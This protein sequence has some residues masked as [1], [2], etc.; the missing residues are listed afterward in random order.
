MTKIERLW[1]LLFLLP[2]LS[3]CSSIHYQQQLAQPP[4][5][6]ARQATPPD[7]RCLA[8]PRRKIAIFFD[9]TANNVESDT[10][11][12][13]L[14]SLVSLQD[15][16]DIATLYIEGV[17]VDSDL[18]GA[19]TG[20]GFRNRVALAYSFLLAHYRA[21]DQIYVFGFSRGAYQAR[22]LAS[23]LYYIGLPD[24]PG[25]ASK[26]PFEDRLQHATTLFDEMKAGFHE[27]RYPCSIAAARAP[28]AGPERYKSRRVEVLGLWD[29]VEALGGGVM[30]WSERLLHKAGIAPFHVD[31]DEPN[32]R[33]GDQL[34]NVNHVFHAV[35]LDDDREWIFTPLLVSRQ[36]LLSNKH[37][38]NRDE[39]STRF[40][41]ACP[42]GSATDSS[43]TEIE[44]PAKP[45]APNIA[46]VW[47]A[48]AH[49]DV[50]GGYVGSDLPGVSLNWMIG[51]L[52]N[53][54]EAGLLPEG[55]RVREDP[56]GSSH[57]P[58]AGMWSPLYHQVNRNLAAHAL[59]QAAACG[60]AGNAAGCGAAGSHEPML[61]L[62]GKLCVHES[63]FQR[64]R[65]MP[66]RDHENR[67]L[68]LLDPGTVCVKASD[69]PGNPR[70]LIQASGP[71]G[72]AGCPDGTRALRIESWQRD[73]A[74]C[75]AFVREAAR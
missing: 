21:C 65:L 74:K 61:G 64:R 72:E 38:P 69:L 59:G 41:D 6:E 18:L 36:H 24:A 63:V 50:G 26:A 10:N 31:I 44:E 45:G 39:R 56:F 35:S 9:G 70:I 5:A 42:S 3:A 58:E 14:H 30:G 15:R 40:A 20:L 19:A 66:P 67:Y 23:V 29:S 47:F 11:V 32:D 34:W 16:P 7:P 27:R 73:G 8:S 4:A 28:S 75:P 22:A 51:L 53:E 46:E 68:D 48:G 62:A 13:R 1:W 43:G 12:K 71:Q 57:D 17:G 25:G 2:A 33:Y 37:L 54:A 49:S 52:K 60:L 55:A